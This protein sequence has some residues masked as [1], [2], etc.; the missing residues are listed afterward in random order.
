M[1]TIV[2]KYLKKIVLREFILYKLPLIETNNYVVK[3][4]RKVSN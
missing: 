3:S 4:H 1:D 2:N